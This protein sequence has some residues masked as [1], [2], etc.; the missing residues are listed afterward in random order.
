M[1]PYFLYCTM[2]LLLFR[3]VELQAGLRVMIIAYLVQGLPMQQKQAIRLLFGLAAELIHLPHITFPPAR[4]W[5]WAAKSPSLLSWR[6][7]IDF[8]V[9]FISE[10]HIN[11]NRFLHCFCFCR[12]G[13]SIR[14]SV[15]CVSLSCQCTPSHLN[16]SDPPPPSFFHNYLPHPSHFHSFPAFFRMTV[17]QKVTKRFLQK[18]STCCWPTSLWWAW[19]AGRPLHPPRPPTIK[20]LVERCGVQRIVKYGCC[21]Y[22]WWLWGKLGWGGEVVIVSAS[23]YRGSWFEPLRDY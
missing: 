11:G 18:V 23:Q 2:L 13:K 15:L 10:R 3:M 8:P 21:C 17:C 7:Y 9:W 6:F 5:D 22:Y 1:S 4:Q 14:S 19:Q 16:H 12:Y 20:T